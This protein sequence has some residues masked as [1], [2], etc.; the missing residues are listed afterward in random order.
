MTARTPRLLLLDNYD[1]FTWNLV[2]YLEELG[3]RVRVELN[4]RVSAAWVAERRFEAV[5]I[6]PGPGCPDD[7]GISLELVESLAGRTPLLGVCLGHQAIAQAFGAR[8]VRA[9]LLVHGKTSTILHDGLGLFSGLPARFEATRYHSLVIDP[10]TLAADLRITAR[11]PEE[12]IM[13]IQH[14]RMPL[15]GVQFHPESILTVQGKGLLNNFLSLA[16]RW[17]ERALQANPS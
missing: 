6:S 11:T 3:A 17:N 12:V 8:I 1:S 5:V 14:C 15:Y 7:A 16:T 2:Q 4:D 10:A 9:P 13:A